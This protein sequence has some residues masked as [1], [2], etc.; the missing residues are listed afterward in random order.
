MSACLP[1]ISTE[2]FSKAEAEPVQGAAMHVLQGLDGYLD[3]MLLQTGASGQAL[4]RLAQA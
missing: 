2:W 1:G 3:R 4:E